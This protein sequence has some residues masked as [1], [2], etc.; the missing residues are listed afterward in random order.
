[1]T[2]QADALAGSARAVAGHNMMATDV[3]PGFCRRTPE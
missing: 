2:T 1:M 3:T